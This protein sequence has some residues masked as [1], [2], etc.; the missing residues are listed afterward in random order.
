MDS[1][2][3]PGLQAQYQKYFGSQIP[4]SMEMKNSD[5]SVL[6]NLPHTFLGS[7][8]LLLNILCEKVALWKRLQCWEWGKGREEKMGMISNK[9]SGLSYAGNECIIRRLA[10]LG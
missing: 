2:T 8:N 5:C 7:N 4:F 10:R 9:V 3:H 6:Y 1:I